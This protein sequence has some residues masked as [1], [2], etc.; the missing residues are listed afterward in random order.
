M[1]AFR[2][3][4]WLRRLPDLVC[5]AVD[6]LSNRT[7]TGRD[8]SQLIGRASVLFAFFVWEKAISAARFFFLSRI[9]LRTGYAGFSRRPARHPASRRRLRCCRKHLCISLFL[10]SFCAL[11]PT[12][13]IRISHGVASWSVYSTGGDSSWMAASALCCT[14]GRTTQIQRRRGAR[15][16]GGWWSPTTVPSSKVFL[17][18]LLCTRIL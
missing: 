1:D 15:T 17:A 3:V 12:V 18:P 14:R 16:S 13:Y 5:V 2:S 9:R 8:R 11:L 6:A 7:G 10:L 4:R